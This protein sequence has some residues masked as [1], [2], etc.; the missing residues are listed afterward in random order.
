MAMKF[1]FDIE[2]GIKDYE[3]LT[4]HKI[5]LTPCTYINLIETIKHLFINRRAQLAKQRTKFKQGF[6]LLE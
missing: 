2:E 3:Q 5:L 4:D 6:D 1:H